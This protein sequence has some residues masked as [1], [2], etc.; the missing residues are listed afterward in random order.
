VRRQLAHI[1]PTED[2]AEDAEGSSSLAGLAD[3]PAAARVIT[4]AGRTLGLVLADLDNCLNP[5]AI[6]LSGEL[7]AASEPL[8][9][10]VRESVNRYARAASA[11]AVTIAI[12]PLQDRSELMG[13]GRH[14]DP[15]LSAV[16]GFLTRSR[17]RS[18]RAG[19]RPSKSSR[20]TY[21]RAASS[22]KVSAAAWPAAFS[23]TSWTVTVKEIRSGAAGREKSKIK[24]RHSTTS[25]V[26]MVRGTFRVGTAY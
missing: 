25:P 8:A 23:R 6:I 15:A 5:A 12:S 9:A 10:G 2:L 20:T 21:R 22:V 1:L 11:S 24:P 17:R 19:R 13:R 7:S 3:Q 4:E 14:R 18:R 26:L 16:G